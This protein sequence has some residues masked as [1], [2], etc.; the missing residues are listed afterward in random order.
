MGIKQWIF[1]DDPYL[2]HEIFNVNGRFT[3]SRPRTAFFTDHYALG[4]K[5]IVAGSPS[6]LWKRTRAAG[7][8]KD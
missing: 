5:G 3:A 1:V 8:K 6:T 7:N 2:A 4:D